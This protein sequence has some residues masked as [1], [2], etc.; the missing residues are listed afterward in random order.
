MKKIDKGLI[1]KIATNTVFH[2]IL[3]VF[4]FMVLF[5]VFW[6]VSTSLRTFEGIYQVS[7]DMDAA[8][9]NIFHKSVQ[10]FK[11]LFPP[12][13]IQWH[14]YVEAWHTGHFSK[15][16]GNSLFY[17]ITVVAFMLF[18]SSLGAYAFARLKFPGKEFIFYLFLA[19]L[20]MPLPTIFITI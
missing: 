8:S 16:F 7:T 11:S 5:P 14:N 9:G 19:S 3:I 4:A 17:M 1:K 12:A 15:Y 18:F 6:G 2:L 10:L 13:P 20:V